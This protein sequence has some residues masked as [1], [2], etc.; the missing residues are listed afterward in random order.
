MRFNGGDFQ[1]KAGEKGELFG[2]GVV[3]EW[4]YRYVCL[5]FVVVGYLVFILYPFTGVLMVL[6]VGGCN[7]VECGVVWL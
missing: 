2:V 3:V 6:I 1:G 5:V 7:R 4:I